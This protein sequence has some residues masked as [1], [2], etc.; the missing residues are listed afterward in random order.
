MLTLNANWKTAF[1]G[2]QRVPVFL[3]TITCND[4]T[5]YRFLCAD[6]NVLANATL[7]LV[8]VEI[9]PASIDD[10]T[11]LGSVGS[12]SLTFV[13]EARQV[14]RMRA[15]IAAKLLK[16]QKVT[17]E[18]GE[19]S[20]SESDYEYLAE[21][22]QIDTIEVGTG[23]IKIALL[24]TVGQMLDKA[25]ASYQWPGHP[26]RVLRNAL[27][28]ALPTG[29]VDTAAFD[30]K[31][32]TDTSHFVVSRHQ[33][34]N[35]SDLDW[36][37]VISGGSSRGSEQRGGTAHGAGI[38]L[39]DTAQP[40]PMRTFLGACAQLVLGSLVGTN[41]GT[42]TLKRFDRAG[43][44]DRTFSEYE[45]AEFKQEEDI[46]RNTY[47]DVRIIGR[48]K[49]N[50]ACTLWRIESTDAKD[51]HAWPGE[52]EHAL[53][54]AWPGGNTSEAHPW[55]NAFQQ[56]QTGSPTTSFDAT[57]TELWLWY[58]HL[59][60]FCGTTVEDGSGNEV[61]PTSTPTQQTEHTLTSDRP[62]YFLI[63]TQPPGTDAA[64]G[65]LPAEIVKATAFAYGSTTVWRE[66]TGPEG[67]PKRFWAWGK[68]T[69]TRGQYG[70]TAQDWST[71]QGLGTVYV[72]DITIPVWLAEQ[73][74]DRHVYG[75]PM[76]SFKVPSRHLDVELGDRVAL[77]RASYLGPSRG[78]TGAGDNGLTTS[79]VWEVVEKSPELFG[80]NPGWRL[81][82]ARI[83]KSDPAA[84]VAWDPKAEIR[85]YSFVLV[86]P[87]P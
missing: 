72:Y 66:V 1:D 33:W 32:F 25:I 9:N 63:T 85:P 17:L 19:V 4:S 39:T 13:D 41:A 69:V 64:D 86:P 62:A 80:A 81:K 73:V 84:L 23:E 22:Q 20:L 36:T 78:S 5:S 27:A 57:E 8:G 40:Q 79:T 15:L 26:C 65:A 48:D 37:Q 18:I 10:L 71:A 28:L 46:Y 11:R 12:L 58:P 3:V 59:F 44:V 61:E 47:N 2:G 56:M 14:G 60:G 35:A 54:L 24:D 83:R 50:E 76:I 53:E 82:C 75:V 7:G 68:Y 52:T 45:V 34:Y 70:T 74:L 87:P 6:R 43:T 31:D 16:G 77:E 21:N 38:F 30:E 55:L 49:D 42:V 67:G 51:D 29:M